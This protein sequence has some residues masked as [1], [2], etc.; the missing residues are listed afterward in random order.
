M[1]IDELCD[2]SIDNITT[3]DAVL[4]LWTTSPLVDAVLHAA[5][6]YCQFGWCPAGLPA[7]DATGHIFSVVAYRFSFGKH[8]RSLNQCVRI[9]NTKLTLVRFY[10]RSYINA[11]LTAEKKVR[12]SQSEAVKIQ[13]IRVISCELKRAGRVRCAQ[14]IM[15]LAKTANGGLSSLP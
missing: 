1:S 10:Q 14:G 13:S 12:R 5:R 15:S 8:L 7:G 11:T 3:L 2:L 9:N 6:L 4:F